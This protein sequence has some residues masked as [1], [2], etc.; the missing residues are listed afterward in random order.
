MSLSSASD[1]S[2]SWITSLDGILLDNGNGIGTVR[3]C[4]DPRGVDYVTLRGSIS[5]LTDNDDGF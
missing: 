5:L 2:E 1:S 3:A 4:Y